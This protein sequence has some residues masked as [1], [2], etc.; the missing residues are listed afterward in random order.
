M[1]PENTKKI[2]FQF[3]ASNGFYVALDTL[4]SGNIYLHLFYVYYR[5]KLLG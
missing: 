1:Y 5:F 4:I 3:L 2:N